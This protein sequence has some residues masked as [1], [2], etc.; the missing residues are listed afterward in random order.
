[1]KI[2]TATIV[3]KDDEFLRRLLD[4]DSPFGSFVDIR[5]EDF[6]TACLECGGKDEDGSAKIV[7]TL[8]PRVSTKA[9]SKP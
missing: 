1:M 4:G 9:E 6:T 5:S 8:V 7:I 2:E 3:L